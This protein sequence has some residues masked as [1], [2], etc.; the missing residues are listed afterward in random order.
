MSP[1]MKRETMAEGF[2]IEVPV[3]QGEVTR[4]VTQGGG[5]W[6]YEI[7]VAAS[8]EALAD[9]FANTYSGRSW[10]VV[11]QGSLTEG[12][13]GVYL[14]LRKGAAESRVEVLDAIGGEPTVARVTVG[15]GTPVLG[16]Y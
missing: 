14:E 10:T 15:V 4:A 13:G 1:E 5:I 2:P 11:G 3:P 7:G 8:P 9:W 6:D 16:T 12:S